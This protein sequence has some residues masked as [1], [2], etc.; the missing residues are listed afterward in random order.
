MHI[1]AVHCHILEHDLGIILLTQIL[2]LT[3]GF[4][5]I[6]NFCECTNTHAEF[7]EILSLV[8]MCFV[9]FLNLILRFSAVLE[10]I[11]VTILQI[12]GLPHLH[13]NKVNG[14]LYSFILVAFPF[15]TRNAFQILPH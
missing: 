13:M 6:L 1:T 9:M 5:Q 3:V 10:M 11:S 7:C 4:R 2:T 12:F 15:H 14:L 8:D